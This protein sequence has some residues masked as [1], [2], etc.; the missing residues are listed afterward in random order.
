MIWTNIMSSIGQVYAKKALDF[1]SKTEGLVYFEQIE[2]CTL[3]NLISTQFCFFSSNSF[4]FFLRGGGQ[5]KTNKNR[6]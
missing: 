3:I 2:I 6:H 4:F 5:T 1:I